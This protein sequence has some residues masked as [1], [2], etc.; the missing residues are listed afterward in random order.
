[1]IRPR[2]R[3]VGAAAA[4]LA[5]A[6]CE[7]P[8]FGAPDSAS[9]QGDRTLRLWQGTFVAA[10]VVGAVVFGLIAFVLVRFRRRDDEIPYQRAH[11]LPLEI[12]YTA[13]P[14]AIVAVLFVFSVVAQEKVTTTTD[15][16]D[17][18]VEVV[19]F[20]WEWQFTY[21]DED[22]T[23]TGLPGAPLPSWCSPSAG[24]RSFDLVAD[25]VVHSFW[26]PG[27]L[28]KRDLIPGVDNTIDID[29]RPHAGRS[30]ACCAEY[31]G[32]DH[33]RMDFTVRV[34]DQT[35]FDAWLDEQRGDD[36]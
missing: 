27:F 3:L 10:M 25:D 14:V 9:K 24:R 5:L 17:L 23:V 6:A 11:N 26:V 35:E 18:R 32:L 28:E 12:V 34:V 8:N 7:L 2:W 33:W 16:P 22:V 21:V 29:A 4:G 19:G 1:M 36:R 31:C 13:I 15:D 30:T 20:Q